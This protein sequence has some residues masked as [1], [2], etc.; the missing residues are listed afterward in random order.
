M[1]VPAAFKPTR[2]PAK[3][4]LPAMTLPPACEPVIVALARLR[5]TN[6]P[7]E[8][9]SPTVMAPATRRSLQC[10]LGFVRQVRRRRRSY[11][12]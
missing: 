6:P 7:A 8:P 5:P 9:P 2:P 11:H 1:P 12:R 4:E 3:A 10:C